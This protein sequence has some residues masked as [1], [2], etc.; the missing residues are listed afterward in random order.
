MRQC[1]SEISCIVCY[2]SKKEVQMS[3]TTA[4]ILNAFPAVFFTSLSSLLST[5]VTLTYIHFVYFRPISGNTVH[6]TDRQTDGRTE[7][8]N[9]KVVYTSR[10]IVERDILLT[11]TLDDQPIRN[12]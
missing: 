8:P 5:D 10:S 11:M 7:R 9:S 3:V 1:L 6:R 4:V 2:L 12:Q